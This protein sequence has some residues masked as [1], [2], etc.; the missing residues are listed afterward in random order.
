MRICEE[1]QKLR[2]WLDENSIEWVDDSTNMPHLEFMNYWICRTKFEYSGCEWSVINGCGTY[3]G[4]R[5]YERRNQGLL[6]IRT[7]CV[8]DG[9]PI[10]FLTF[11]HLKKYLEQSNEQK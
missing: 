3:G 1:M 11:E 8:N 5:A 10:G 4:F 6:E 7:S 2:D 9:D